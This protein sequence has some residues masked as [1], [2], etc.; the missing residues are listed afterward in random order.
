MWAGEVLMTCD[1][2]IATLNKLFLQSSQL[3]KAAGGWLT[4][5]PLITIQ[6]LHVVVQT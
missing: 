6:G 4:M 5:H 2:H 1:L 3:S